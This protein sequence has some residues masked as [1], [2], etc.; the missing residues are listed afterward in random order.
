MGSNFL[1]WFQAWIV[2]LKQF[3]SVPI[4]PG[5]YD[6]GEFRFEGAQCPV[7]QSTH[8]GISKIELFFH[9]YQYLSENDD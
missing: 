1:K 7:S 2:F 8:S 4:F 9:R 3:P 5:E 6:K